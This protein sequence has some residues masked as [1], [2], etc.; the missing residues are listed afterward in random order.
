LGNKVRAV[1][2]LEMSSLSS[3][4]M[5]SGTTGKITKFDIGFRRING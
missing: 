2:G 4:R 3:W 1:P 5:G